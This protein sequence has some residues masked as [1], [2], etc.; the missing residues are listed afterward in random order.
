M[1]FQ[2]NRWRD[3]RRSSRNKRRKSEEKKP[4]KEEKKKKDESKYRG[5]FEVI[6]YDEIVNKDKTKK[7]DKEN[8]IGLNSEKDHW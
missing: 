5:L 6:D 3:R 4:E 8:D 1:K 7:G 2:A